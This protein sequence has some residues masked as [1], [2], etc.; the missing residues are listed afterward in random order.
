MKSARV[1]MAMGA[2]SMLVLGACENKSPT[3]APGATPN[4]P[5]PS[6]GASKPAPADELK[7]QATGTDA[8]GTTPA[9]ESAPKPEEKPAAPAPAPATA[10]PAAVPAVEAPAPREDGLVIEDLQIGDGP[11]VPKGA[12]VVVHYKGTLKSDGTEFD[13]SYKRGQPA[14]FPL[15]NLIKGWQEGIP[16]MKPGGKRKLTVPYA[17]A[18]GENGR[19]PVI[20]P[21]ADLVFEIELVDFVRWEDTKVGEGAECKPNQTVQVYYRGTLKSNGKEF[22]SNMGQ[23]PIEFP[24][25]DLIPGW[26]YGIPGMKVGGTRKLTIPWQFAYGERGSPPTIPPKADLNFEIQLLGVK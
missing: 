1:L 25:R 22:D 20:P 9:G 5:A 3:T 23:E 21:K 24:L 8:A 16:G 15:Q 19:P 6:H 2:M 12:A 26:Q 14:A 13:S 7:P 17:L 10:P 11:S 18:Y 4:A